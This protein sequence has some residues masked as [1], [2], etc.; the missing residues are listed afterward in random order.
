M[1]WSKGIIASVQEMERTR[2]GVGILLND[3][4]LS[5]V[6]DFRGVTFR[7]LCGGRVWPQ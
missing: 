4:W 6:I 5:D 3:V 1:V 7:I 2:E